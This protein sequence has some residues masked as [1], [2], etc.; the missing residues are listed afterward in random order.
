MFKRIVEI[1][2]KVRERRKRTLKDGQEAGEMLLDIEGRIGELL[3]PREEALKTAS[4]N[5]K[6]EKRLEGITM[7]RAVHARAISRHPEIVEK[8]KAQAGV[9]IIGRKKNQKVELTDLEDLRTRVK[10]IRKRKKGIYERFTNQSKK[11][12]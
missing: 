7:K 8:V 6:R 1:D 2:F 9:T 10:E 4:T 11:R 5:G 12:R 3:P